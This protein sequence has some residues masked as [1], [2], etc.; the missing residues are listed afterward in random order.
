MLVLDVDVRLC[1]SCW[2]GYLFICVSN[3]LNVV[4]V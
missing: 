1:V 3:A 2:C 4:V